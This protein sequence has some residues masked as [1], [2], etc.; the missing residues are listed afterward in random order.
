LEASDKS[1]LSGHPDTSSRRR[2]DRALF[3][4]IDRQFAAAAGTAEEDVSV[5]RLRAAFIALLPLISTALALVN[6]RR[7]D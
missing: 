5:A 3:H 1:Q 2:H 6:A 4:G 7:W